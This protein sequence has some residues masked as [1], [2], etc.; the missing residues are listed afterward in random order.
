MDQ[1]CPCGRVA[2]GH[3]LACTSG[4]TAMTH[5][6]EIRSLVA[7]LVAGPPPDYGRTPSGRRLYRPLVVGPVLMRRPGRRVPWLV[8]VSA[9]GRLTPRLP[10][11]AGRLE[12][13]VRRLRTSNAH[14]RVAAALVA[15]Q[16]LVGPRPRLIP[17]DRWPAAEFYGW[18]IMYQ[19]PGMRA[20]AALD[21]HERHTDLPAFYESPAELID[22]SE[23]L[24][25]RDIPSRPI[26]LL[27]QPTD[28]VIAPD[29]QTCNRFY[30]GERFR[31]PVDLEWFA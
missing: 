20:L 11:E 22:R 25:A 5:A 12:R 18:A 6:L 1:R 10:A 3:A 31:P 29:G 19:L 14:H 30:P 7:R 24:A 8:R 26:A 13:Q 23:Y 4:N 9:D 2:S 15:P 21:P 16:D 17:H 27:T 28:F